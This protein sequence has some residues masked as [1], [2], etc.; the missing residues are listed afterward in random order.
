V[1]IDVSTNKTV[2]CV[3]AIVKCKDEAEAK[4]RRDEI[5]AKLKAEFAGR[6]SEDG[7]KLLE[8]LG[9]KDYVEVEFTTCDFRKTTDENNRLAAGGKT[10]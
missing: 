9:G 2:M 3:S 5:A 10:R 6:I 7:D 8:V 1:S 4:R